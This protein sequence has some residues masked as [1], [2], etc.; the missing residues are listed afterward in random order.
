MVGLKKHLHTKEKW[1]LRAIMNI[2]AG[3]GGIQLRAN[4]GS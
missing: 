1:A 4:L 2:S 3:E